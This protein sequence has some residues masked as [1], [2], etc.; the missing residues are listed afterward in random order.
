MN[1]QSGPRQEGRSKSYTKLSPKML[2]QVNLQ[3]GPRQE[4]RSKS[5]T[6]LSPKMLLRLENGSKMGDLKKHAIRLTSTSVVCTMSG[7]QKGF[8]VFGITTV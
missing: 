4:G 7:Y 5:Y 2:L 1:L 3:S 8:K 6:K